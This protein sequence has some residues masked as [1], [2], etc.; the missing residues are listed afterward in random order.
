MCSPGPEVCLAP[1]EA[2]LR[3]SRTGTPSLPSPSLRG[4]RETTEDSDTCC[5]AQ[6]QSIAKSTHFPDEPLLKPYRRRR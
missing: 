6:E 4:G 1:D 2:G 5:V 3:E